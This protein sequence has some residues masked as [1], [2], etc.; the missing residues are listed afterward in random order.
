MQGRDLFFSM[1]EISLII[2][3]FEE[4]NEGTISI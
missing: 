4:C 3:Y 2:V 1:N